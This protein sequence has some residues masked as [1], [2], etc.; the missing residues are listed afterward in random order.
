MN[1]I[2]AVVLGGIPYTRLK[3]LDGS[4]GLAHFVGWQVR[5][6]ICYYT[7]DET[8]QKEIPM[9]AYNPL[10][11][12]AF[13]S[14]VIT[15][16]TIINREKIVRFDTGEILDFTKDNLLLWIEDDAALSKSVQALSPEEVEE[17]LFKCLLIYDDRNLVYL[18]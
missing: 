1:K 9:E 11:G 12:K 13:R 16:E 17:K 10:T 3:A 15:R 2:W 7:Y 18:R 8:L 5:G 6:K 4:S 14:G